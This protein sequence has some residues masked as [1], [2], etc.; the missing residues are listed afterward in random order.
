MKKQIGILY[1]SPTGTTESVCKQMAAGMGDNDPQMLNMTSPEIRKYLISHSL[2]VPDTID[3]L[4]VGA[5]VHSGKLPIQV[6]KC[7]RE[8]D[9]RA[10]ECSAIVVYGNR[11]YGIALRSMVELLS[12]AG[13]DVVSAG[14]FIGQHAYSDIV[15]I[16]MN[17][18][19]NSDLKM[20]L[21]FGFESQY[22][23]KTLNTDDIPIQLDKYSTSSEYTSLKPSYNETLCRQCGIC[24]VA[25]PLGLIK[26]DNG[27]FLSP[28]LKKQCIG[29]MACVKRCKQKARVV[30]ANPA[31]K[32]IMNRLLKKAVI[33][34]QEPLT[35]IK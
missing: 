11:D 12:D 18:P 28:L 22:A 25:C 15:P 21:K 30:K 17:R 33:D 1:F 8:L 7:L 26:S 13:F 27:Q 16:A 23:T 10:M 32:L 31:V 20:A 2:S 24:S 5:P 14:A 35:I 34:F 19:D 3:H 29:C 9:G 6:A 4:I